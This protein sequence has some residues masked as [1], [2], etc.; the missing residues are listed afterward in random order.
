MI[1]FIQIQAKLLG[2]Y[3]TNSCEVKTYLFLLS[4]PCC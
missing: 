2:L 1:S 3:C 4:S